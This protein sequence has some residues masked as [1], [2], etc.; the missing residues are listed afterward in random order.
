MIALRR[1]MMMNR[2]IRIVE[3]A[4]GAESSDAECPVQSMFRQKRNEPPVMSSAIRI[5]NE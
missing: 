5:E 1:A 2:P 3:N 4:T